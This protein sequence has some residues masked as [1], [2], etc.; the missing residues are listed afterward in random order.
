M[1]NCANVNVILNA[2]LFTHIHAF[3]PFSHY[4][5]IAIPYFH[6][7]ICAEKACALCV[8]ECMY[9]GCM[10]DFH[11]TV[12]DLPLF[13]T[14][15]RLAPCAPLDPFLLRSRIT[16]SVSCMCVY[17]LPSKNILL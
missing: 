7:I 12:M 5:G 2:R 16:L 3:T 9:A 6:I 10:N 15:F 4:S 11:S 13:S 14:I 1:L 8:Y 17:V